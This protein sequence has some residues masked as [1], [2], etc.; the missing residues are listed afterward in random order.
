MAD[1]PRIDPLGR[2]AILTDTQVRIAFAPRD[3]EAKIIA[4][5]VPVRAAKL[6]EMQLL[7]QLGTIH[8]QLKAGFAGERHLELTGPELMVLM[9]MAD[10]FV[11]EL[12]RAMKAAP[13]DE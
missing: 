3:P 2:A 1:D 13:E 11:T 7:M 12:P 6:D 8:L 9:E 10:R 5:K 4:L